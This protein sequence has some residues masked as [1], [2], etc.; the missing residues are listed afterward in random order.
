MSAAAEGTVSQRRASEILPPPPSS[1]AQTLVLPGDF[2]AFLAR[3]AVEDLTTTFVYISDIKG[4]IANAVKSNQT[5]TASPNQWTIEHLGLAD[6]LPECTLPPA[7]AAI[8]RRMPYHILQS[9]ACK[10]ALEKATRSRLH[11]K[12]HELRDVP[13]NDRSLQTQGIPA[14]AA[15]DDLT[16]LYEYLFEVALTLCNQYPGVNSLEVLKGNDNKYPSMHAFVPAS[17]FSAFT[18]KMA[19]NSMEHL[20]AIYRQVSRALDSNA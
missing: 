6:L 20:K 3:A 2:S 18:E 7:D 12:L 17:S 4:V 14:D 10:D 8:L 16:D 15:R 13:E 11:S 9:D 5:R 1:S 19:Q